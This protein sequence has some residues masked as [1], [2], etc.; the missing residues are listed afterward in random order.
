LLAL[1]TACCPPSPTPAPT[2]PIRPTPTPSVTPPLADA[3]SPIAPPIGPPTAKT[4]DVVESQF[5]IEVSDPYRW[6]ESPT[7][8]VTGELKDW[9]VA[10]GDF[11]AMQF[12]AAPHRD[13]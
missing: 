7:N 11:A 5:G 10:Q 12:A 4:V 3:A 13:E 9:V 6:M 2:N 8:E 1:I